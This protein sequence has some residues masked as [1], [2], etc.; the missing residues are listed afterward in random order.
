MAG[1]PHAGD[2]R[3]LIVEQTGGDRGKTSGERAKKPQ[4]SMVAH[5]GWQPS[6]KR[7][8]WVGRRPNSPQ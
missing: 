6:R 1:Q 2:I 5:S 4:V 7:R 3:S 8:P